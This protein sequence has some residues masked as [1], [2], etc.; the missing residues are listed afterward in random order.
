VCVCERERAS[1]RERER[2][3]EYVCVSRVLFMVSRDLRGRERE[4]V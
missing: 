3:R 4:R 1:E 2:E